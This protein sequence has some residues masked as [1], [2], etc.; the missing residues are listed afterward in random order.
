MP[1]CLQGHVR[2]TNTHT[3]TRMHARPSNLKTQQNK[4]W[5]KWGSFLSLPP[6]SLPPP[7][8]LCPSRLYPALFCCLLPPP[9]IPFIFLSSLLLSHVNT[10]LLSGSGMPE[11]QSTDR[12]P[13]TMTTASLSC[14]TP[15]RHWLRA[16][17]GGGSGERERRVK[18]RERKKQG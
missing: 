2:Y 8:P 12:S 18:E 7:P 16:V 10:M 13:V 5:S 15:G 4:S 11:G 3:N 1:G 9:P 6:Q 17:G 14:L